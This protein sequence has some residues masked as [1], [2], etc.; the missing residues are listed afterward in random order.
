M[1]RRAGRLGNPAEPLVRALREL[2]GGDAAQHVHWGATSQ[3]IIDSAAMLV[4]PRA[5][6]T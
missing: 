1:P 4:A 6:S 2:V 3:D 5:R